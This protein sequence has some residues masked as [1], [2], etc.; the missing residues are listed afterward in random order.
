MD[1]IVPKIERLEFYF[2]SF[3][4]NALDITCALELVSRKSDHE[5]HLIVWVQLR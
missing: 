3:P 5:N 4:L 2:L 1:S